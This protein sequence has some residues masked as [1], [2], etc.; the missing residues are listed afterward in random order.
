MKANQNKQANVIDDS[1]KWHF[2][3]MYCMALSDT[4][5]DP[6]EAELLYKIGLEH[7]LDKNV[8][9]EIV[10]TSGLRPEIPIT[11]EEK[12]SYLYDLTRMAWADGKIEGEEQLVLQKNILRFGFKDENKEQIMSY[13][14]ESVRNAKSLDQIINE[15]KV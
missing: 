1:L 5:F 14:I 13:L 11:M 12:V 10:V 4:D 7:G 15:I 3:N 2:F 8:I 9:D 6:K